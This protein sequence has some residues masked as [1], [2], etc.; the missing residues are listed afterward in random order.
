MSDLPGKDTSLWIATTKTTKYPGFGS[1][2][3]T[4]D[5]AVIGGGITG[6]LTAYKLQAAGLN[7]VILEKNRIVE[8]TTG[9]TTAKLTSQH[10]LIYT[11]LVKEHGEEVAKT[12]ASANQKAVDDIEALANKLNIDCDFLRTEAYVYTNQ[13]QKIDEILKEV[14]VTKKLGLPSSFEEKIDLPL[15]A[16][17]AI[18]F[19][20]QAQ[21]HPRKF[22]LPLAEET[23][24]LGGRIFEET[25]VKDIETGP[26]TNTVVTQNGRLKAKYVVEA[27]KYPFWQ[28]KLFEKAYWTKLSYAL[29]VT[30]GGDY[31]HG[32]YITTDDPIRTIRAHP[33]KDGQILIFGGESHKLTKDY[34]KNQHY[35]KL[36][37]DVNKYFKVK[38][39]IY[40]WI[41]GDAMSNDKMP[42]IGAYPAHPSVY[43]ATGYRAWGLAWAMA[44]SD[45]ISGSILG[46]PADWAEPFSLKRLS[47]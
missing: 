35:Q 16:K 36:I 25:E 46:K 40:R 10:Y 27:T 3:E 41:A 13:A 32:M 44:A 12:Y 39:I 47:D 11:D 7:T 2:N 21:F 17:G 31:P 28:P 1:Q 22:L 42:Y 20:N 15:P 5:V 34:D 26:T 4:C 38:E 23:V 19:T 37:D 6:I 8:N 24:K 43:I 33:Y 30:I 14:D 45:A 18:K 29:G 9:N